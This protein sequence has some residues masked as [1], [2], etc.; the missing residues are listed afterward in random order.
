MLQQD[1]NYF[2]LTREIKI[3][4]VFFILLQTIQITQRFSNSVASVVNELGEEK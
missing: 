1:W 3:C 2:V 4:K